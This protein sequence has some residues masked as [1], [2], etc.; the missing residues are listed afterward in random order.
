MSPLYYIA[1]LAIALVL[2]FSAN[3][4]SDTYK[5]ASEYETASEQADTKIKTALEWLTFGLY[6]GAS[7]KTQAID[8]LL[9]A[10]AYHER[11]VIWSAWLLFVLSGVFLISAAIRTN[12][13]DAASRRSLA[14]HLLGVSAICLLVGL[15]APMLTV[16]A[17]QDVTL[18]GKVVFQY[19]SRSIIGTAEGLASSGNIAVAV[20]LFLFSAVIP[21][22]KLLLSFVAL[23]S[24]GSSVRTVAV[25]IIRLIGK[26]SMTDVFVVAVLLAFLSTES[27]SLTDASVGPGLYFFAAYGL[28]SLLGG[29]Q[30]LRD[31]PAE[32]PPLRG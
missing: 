20:L 8:E 9:A 7:E 5:A 1:A 29:Q 10:A 11:R 17:H 30:L 22:A 28:L 32:A 14:V 21:V 31:A 3:T 16:V 4:V 2:V 15:V 18:L 6:S 19:E 25:K 23:S 24:A 13:H 12:R 26:W 27:K